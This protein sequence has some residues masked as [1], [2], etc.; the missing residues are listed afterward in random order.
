LLPS[1]TVAVQLGL[2][3]PLL[4]QKILLCYAKTAGDPETLTGSK[5]RMKQ[6][7]Y[8]IFDSPSMMCK[9]QVAAILMNGVVK[10]VF[11]ATSHQNHTLFG[12]QKRQLMLTINL[13]LL[14]IQWYEI[15][16]ESRNGRRGT[17]LQ[18]KISPAS[19]LVFD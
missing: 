15:S 9:M 16:H 18:S 3:L 12:S 6:K 11:D 10:H 13:L 17:H 19:Y 14:L 8:V 1:A 2:L 5:Q 7:V 4:K